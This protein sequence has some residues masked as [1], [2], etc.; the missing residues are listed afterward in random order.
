MEI[1]ER[2]AFQINDFNLDLSNNV[3]RPTLNIEKTIP[4]LA[5]QQSQINNNPSGSTLTILVSEILPLNKK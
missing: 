5:D 3:L 2:I 4:N 1:E